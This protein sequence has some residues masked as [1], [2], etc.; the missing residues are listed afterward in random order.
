[1][2]STLNNAEITIIDY[3]LGNLRSIQSKLRML[4]INAHITNQKEEILS[5]QRLL[6]PGVGHFAQGMK[7][8]R[9]L[10]LIDALNEQ[11]LEKKIPI[12]GICLGMQLLARSSEEGF[13][14]GLGWL[15]AEVVR[16]KVERP[17][18]VPH[19]GWNYLNL[20]EEGNPLYRGLDLKK[21][22]YFT[23]SYCFQCTD[24]NSAAT[25]THY[26]QEFVSSIHQGNIFGTQFHPEKSRLYGLK[27]LENFSKVC[28]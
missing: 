18:R 2:R 23:H 10:N 17:F 13:E 8:L 3:G 22:F 21:P 1:M 4:K 16:L 20:K 28:A 24:M 15:D 27:I 9:D 14:R 6:L 11:V 5:A 19:V 12:L 7:N 25:T 26:G